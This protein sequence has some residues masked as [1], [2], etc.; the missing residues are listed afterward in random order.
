MSQKSQP[1]MEEMAE[2]MM[3]IANRTKVMSWLEKS[4]VKV[5]EHGDEC[6]ALLAVALKKKCDKNISDVCFNLKLEDLVI[7]HISGPKT[8]DVIVT[9]I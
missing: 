9:S 1:S 4:F 3:E 7:S 5:G 6:R 2:V 8:F